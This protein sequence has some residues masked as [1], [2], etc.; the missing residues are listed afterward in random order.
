VSTIMRTAA[1]PA[2]AN[3]RLVPL[4]RGFDGF[5]VNGGLEVLG[6]DQILN[7]AR[8]ARGPPDE[9]GAFEGEHHQVHAG[10]RDSEVPL[11][12][13]LD[14]AARATTPVAPCSRARSRGSCVAVSV[15]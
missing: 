4:H 8:D 11:H 3:N 7:A 13:C 15:G 10:R 9:A 5:K 6:F 1:S 2:Y 14:A 12:V